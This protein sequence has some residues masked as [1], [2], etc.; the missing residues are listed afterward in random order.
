MKLVVR[1][2]KKNKFVA[3]SAGTIRMKIG[4]NSY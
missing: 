1:H 4:F 2:C 3:E